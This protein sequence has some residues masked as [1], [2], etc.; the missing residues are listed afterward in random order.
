MVKDLL[1]ISKELLNCLNTNDNF[2]KEE[3]KYIINLVNKTI[4]LSIFELENSEN[5]KVKMKLKNVNWRSVLLAILFLIIGF[6]IGMVVIYKII[7]NTLIDHNVI[8]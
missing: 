3:S 7:L 4:K 1:Y 6:G 8:I 2:S 5:S